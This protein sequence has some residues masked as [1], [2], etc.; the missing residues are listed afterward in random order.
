MKHP[1]KTVVI[2]WLN[3]IWETNLPYQAKYLACYLRKFMNS[4]NDMAYPSYA[5]IIHET[6]LSRSTIARYMETLEEEGWIVRDKGN[7]GKN[8]TYTA[9]FPTSVTQR[10]VS[11]RPEL[12]S[13][14]HSTSV[15]ETHELN[16]E[17]NK[18]VNNSGPR[19]KFS[20]FSDWK[21]ERQTWEANCFRSGINPDYSDQQLHEFT[22]YWD[23]DKTWL[24]EN[25]WQG[26]LI[27]SLRNQPKQPD[28][29]KKEFTPI[30]DDDYKELEDAF[31]QRN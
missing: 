8:T 19:S 25:Q 24:L 20:M 30:S 21:P 10:L 15:R 2:D 29:L 16:K 4:H 13:Q 18:E 1:P 6:G 12:V 31:S 28:Q 7:V 14:G 3:T 17:L 26:K 5:R 22:L 27:N 23:D 11:E 9:C